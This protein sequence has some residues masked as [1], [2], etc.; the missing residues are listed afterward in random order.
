MISSRYAT[1]VAVLLSLALIPTVIH[2]YLNLAIDNSATTKAIKADLGTFISVP[3][4][5]NPDW[6]A[7]TF[8]CTDWFERTYKDKQG[9]TARLFV[10]RAYDHKR[11]YHHP[12][13]ALSH[14]EDLRSNGQIVLSDVLAIPVHLLHHNTRPSIAAYALFYDGHFI[15]DPI[16]HQI[17][18][19]ISLLVSPEQPMTLFYIAEDN[20]DNQTAFEKTLSAKVLQEAIRSFLAQ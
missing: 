20:L 6:G 10:G 8:G 2:N 14:G 5:R 1:P 7:D 9:N 11:L 12:E 4:R 13:L 3:T 16:A 19:S 18:N 17:K 15:A